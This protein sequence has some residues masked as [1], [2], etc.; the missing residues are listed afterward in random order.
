MMKCSKNLYFWLNS[1]FLEPKFIPIQYFT[2]IVSCFVP[3]NSFCV[4]IFHTFIFI[5]VKYEGQIQ[6]SQEEEWKLSSTPTFK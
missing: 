3:I 6:V 2:K 5:L 1:R 4:F